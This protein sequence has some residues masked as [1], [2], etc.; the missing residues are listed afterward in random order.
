MK[1]KGLIYGIIIFIIAAGFISGPILLR[2]GKATDP[3]FHLDNS[4]SYLLRDYDYQRSHEQLDKAIFAMRELEKRLDDEGK[5][6][7]EKSISDLNIIAREIEERAL[8]KADMNIAYAEALNAL[9]FAEIKISEHLLEIDASQDAIIELKYGMLHLRNA[10]KYAEDDNLKEFEMHIYEELDSL[11]A[12]KSL[13]HDEMKERLDQ[14]L[15]ELGHFVDES[16][17]L[18]RTER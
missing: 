16:D 6:I 14:M 15:V 9:T 10:L 1:G 5:K 17:S 2:N 18:L 12:N 8:V 11:I 4:R 13:S 3:D 7:I